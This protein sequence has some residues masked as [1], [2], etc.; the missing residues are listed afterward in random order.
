VDQLER[1]R[2]SF[3][4]R[5]WLDAYEQLSRADR[6][7]PLGAEDI[8][9]LSIAAFMLGRDEF[10]NLLER[11]HHACLE[12]GDRLMAVRCAFWLG[13]NL[14]LRGEVG[15]GTGWIGRAQ[16]LLEREAD[17][18][19]ER[20]YLLMPLMFRHEAAGDLEAAAS[21]ADEAIEVAERF[22]DADLL[23][24]AVH[25]QGRVLIRSGK[26]DEGLRLLDEAMV[27]VSAGRLS[28]LVAGIVY[29]GVILACEEAFERRRAREWTAALTRWCADQ[30]GI[31][32]FTGRCLVHRAGI[33]RLDGAWADALEEARLAGERAGLSPFGTAQAFYLQGEVLRLQGE[34]AA[35]EEAYREASNRGLE[36]QPG[37][38]QLRLAQGKP[39][40][41]AAALRRALDETTEPLRRAR[42]LPAHV[43]VLLALGDVDGARDACRELEEL[44]RGYA[45]DMLE[46]MVSHA[47]G[48]VELAGGD[49][50]AALPEL[51]QSC[52]L[53]Q[54]LEAP[55]EAARVRVLVGLACRGLG[56]DDSAVLELDSARVVF[57]R[58]GAEPDAARVD[59]LTVTPAAGETHRLSPRELEVLRLLAAGHSN[60]E[61]ASSLVI[62]EHTVARHVQNIFRKLH[63][64]SRTAAGAFAYEHDLV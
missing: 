10:L 58:L 59:A 45:S 6:A 24:L 12:E 17:D 15:P 20:G 16:R 5:S 42:L 36:P 51:R 1:G 28:P 37:L 32:A 62:S 7:M 39:R 25:Q 19:A 23:A 9:L 4:G 54:D 41:A 47:R 27:S 35:A 63:V 49:A 40:A 11:A 13:M 34:H 38:A 31:V 44:A 43:E 18:C 46:A 22:E 48:A 53:W 26:Y 56:D 29:C 52:R 3:A 61:I 60:R 33:M 50:R 14:M 2:E 30:S 57:R 64:S 21:V 8:G 55:Y